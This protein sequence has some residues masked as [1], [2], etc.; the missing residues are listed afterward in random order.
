MTGFKS[1]TSVFN[2]LESSGVNFERGHSKAELKDKYTKK[3]LNKT[4]D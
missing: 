2:G 4:Q 3:S 1:R